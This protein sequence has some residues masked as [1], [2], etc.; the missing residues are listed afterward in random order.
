[1][2]V[3]AI[4]LVFHQKSAVLLHVLIGREALFGRSLGQAWH[5][6]LKDPAV[7]LA[8][9]ELLSRTIRRFKILANSQVTI[10]INTP[11]KLDPKF[12][13]FPYLAKT[14]FAMSFIG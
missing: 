3:I 9:S 2:G 7:V 11:R 14:G 1:M 12:I 4:N 6:V 5:A 13:L 8:D 10:G